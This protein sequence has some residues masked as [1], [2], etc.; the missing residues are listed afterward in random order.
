[1]EFPY[2]SPIVHGIERRHLVDP[3]WGHFKNSSYLVHHGDGTESVLALPEVKNRHHGG[4]LVLRG[5]SAENGGDE[6]LVLGGE[7]EGDGGVVCWG[8]SV[9]GFRSGQGEIPM[10]GEGGVGGKNRETYDS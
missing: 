8:I 5:V 4:F 10:R 6:L 9:L 3:H 1:M 2:G 7:F